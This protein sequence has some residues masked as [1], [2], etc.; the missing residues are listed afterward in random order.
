M[1]NL[2]YYRACIG[3]ILL[4]MLSS[5]G[6][7]PYYSTKYTGKSSVELNKVEPVPVDDIYG[8]EYYDVLLQVL[9]PQGESKYLLY[10][11]LV[12]SKELSILQPNSDVLRED[13]IVNVSY[14]LVRKSDLQEMV[15]G[16]FRRNLS[17]STTFAAYAN[18][19]RNNDS[20]LQLA[21]S[22]AAE[23][24]NRLVLYFS[25]LSH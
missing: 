3:V 20:S 11:T 13:A 23:V 2:I 6:L 4:L 8:A 22:V 5:C 14:K 19:V 7:Q 18:E 1:I 12:F 25:T 21:K 15:S 17:Y 24:R 9:M 16:S 10:S